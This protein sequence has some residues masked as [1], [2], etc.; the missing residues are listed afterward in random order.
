MVLATGLEVLAFGGLHGALQ[1]PR[2]VPRKWDSQGSFHYHS[3][4]LKGP[5]TTTT[6]KVSNH[7]P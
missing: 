5:K 3:I 4:H 2:E 7:Q 6:K 1:S